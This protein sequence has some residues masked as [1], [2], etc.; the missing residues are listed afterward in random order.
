MKIGGV[1]GSAPPSIGDLADARAQAETCSARCTSRRAGSD[2]AHQVPSWAVQ[3]SSTARSSSFLLLI[4]DLAEE[5]CH[6][7]QWLP[8]YSSITCTHL[9]LRHV[10]A[11]G[12]L[13]RRVGRRRRGR[14]Y[15]SGACA[16]PY[17]DQIRRR[18]A[19]ARCADRSL[20]DISASSRS[21]FFQFDR[22]ARDMVPLP[23]IIFI[24]LVYKATLTG[25]HFSRIRLMV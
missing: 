22:R 10:H 8:I 12:D 5:T 14:A 15:T 16:T 24:I 2:R 1:L 11:R 21:I 18:Q 25:A 7:S 13:I 9:L 19:C 20:D 23:F 17:I 3:S 4:S 6:F